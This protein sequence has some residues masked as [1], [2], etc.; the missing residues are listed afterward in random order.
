MVS[1]GDVNA[2]DGDFLQNMYSAGSGADAIGQMGARSPAL[3]IAQ[4]VAFEL[5][6]ASSVGGPPLEECYGGRR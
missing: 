6:P 1:G 3:E 4:N 2:Q 5:V